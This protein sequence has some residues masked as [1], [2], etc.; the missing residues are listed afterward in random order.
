MSTPEAMGT[1]VAPVPRD[2]ITDPELVALIERCEAVGVPDDLFPRILAHVP[3]YAKALL[4]ALLQSHVEGNVDHRLK[5]IIRVHLARI[6]ADPYFG[7]LRSQLATRDGL[8]EA[9][10]AAGAAHFEDDPQFTAAEKSALRYAHQMYL[11]PQSIDAAFYDE[12]KRHWSEAQVMELG[13]FIAFHYGMQVFMRT[14]STAN[15]R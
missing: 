11:D 8:E 14:L 7:R 13:S 2:R 5:E 1:H 6:A 10:I 15:P 9:R 4:R 3:A 12:L